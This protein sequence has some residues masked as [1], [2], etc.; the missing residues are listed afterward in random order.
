MMMCCHLSAGGSNW[1]QLRRVDTTYR[2]M[3]ILPMIPVPCGSCA[4][5]RAGSP[6]HKLT[7][8][9]FPPTA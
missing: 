5:T 1:C 8:L 7:P 4:W 2:G 9:L 6:C 3:G